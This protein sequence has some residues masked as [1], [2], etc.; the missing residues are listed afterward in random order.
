MTVTA[1]MTNPYYD[2]SIERWVIDFK[3]PLGQLCY[4]AIGTSKY[5]ALDRAN[6]LY[7][8]LQMLVP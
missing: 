2:K 1:I 6:F 4:S 5:E 3:T 7:K 8:A